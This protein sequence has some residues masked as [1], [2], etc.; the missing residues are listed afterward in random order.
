M[1]KLRIAN[2]SIGFLISMKYY[3]DIIQF[4]LCELVF[5]LFAAEGQQDI[6]NQVRN[7]AVLPKG[8]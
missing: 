4:K 1:I 6:K 2:N 7:T 8:R 3:N 5:N